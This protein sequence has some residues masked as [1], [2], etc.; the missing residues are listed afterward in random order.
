MTSACSSRLVMNGLLPEALHQV[1]AYFQALSEPTCLQILNSTRRS[2]TLANWPSCAA[3]ARPTFRHLSLL[4]QHALV[5][6]ESRG[7]SAYYRIADASIY[8]L[9]DLVRQHRSQAGSRRRRARIVRSAGRGA[10]RAIAG[11][12]LDARATCARLTANAHR[13][14]ESVLPKSAGVRLRD[15]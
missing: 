11:P 9:C 10:Y 1:A 12:R 8:E 2:A 15:N 3:I 6:R 14:P 5:A 4:T 13:L 7:N